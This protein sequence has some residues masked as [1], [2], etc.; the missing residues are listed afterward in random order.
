MRGSTGRE[1]YILSSGVNQTH[2]W[3][4]PKVGAGHPCAGARL[5]SRRV[6][7]G[8]KGVRACIKAPG[9][10]RTRPCSVHA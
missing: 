3:A 4:R 7:G 5:F 9:G 6:G 2:E 1:L 8:Y 10:G